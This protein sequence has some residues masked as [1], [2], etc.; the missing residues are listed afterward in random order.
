M[1]MHSSKLPMSDKLG[2]SHACKFSSMCRFYRL[3]DA[4]CNN[5]EDAETYCSTYHL[6]ENFKAP[7]HKELNQ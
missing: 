7:Q 6:F 1:V 5:K 3:A 2:E 4:T